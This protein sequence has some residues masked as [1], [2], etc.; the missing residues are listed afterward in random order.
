MKFE[1]L[2][3]LFIV[4]YA[5][6]QVMFNSVWIFVVWVTVLAFVSGFYVGIATTAKLLRDG[7]VKGYGRVR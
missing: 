5:V 2:L 7:K 6:L 1:G 4:L 3:F